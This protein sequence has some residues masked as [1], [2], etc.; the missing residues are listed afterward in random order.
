V[1]IGSQPKPARNEAVAVFGATGHT[2]RFVVSE[3]LRRGI[4]PIAIG[5]NAAK[6][7]ELGRDRGIELREASTDDANSLDRAFE[8]AAA[9]IN[10]AGP[11][12]GTA[13][14]V[15]SGALRSGIHYLDVTAEQASARAT[16]ETF[17]G[18]AR[19]AGVVVMPAMGFFGGFA[20]L[21]VTVAMNGWE[22]ADEITIGI[23]L[24]RW[25]PTRGT[26]MTGERNAAPRLC[27]VDG[28][29]VPV[30]RPPAETDW[31]FPHPFGRQKVIELPFSEV[32]LVARHIRTSELHTHLGRKALLDI[33]NP[34]TPPPE[35]ADDTGLSAQMFLVE[36]IVEAGGRTR[37]IAGRGRDIYAF[38]APLVCEAAERLLD[39]RALGSGARSPG[40]AFDA[41]DFLSTL[42][43]RHLTFE[44][45]DQPHK[46]SPATKARKGTGPAFRARS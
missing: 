40:A 19:D 9:V 46:T 14:P 37:R 36:A 4:A 1:V 29:L 39:G 3:L 11:F 33:R 24:D 5:R 27:I 12:L 13:Q 20:D 22:A 32:V 21:L 7:A 38:S 18:P 2:G 31:D 6:L 15:A 8:G 42:A 17:D 34:T 30:P 45:S 25:H 10:C 41:R 23:A 43:P 44:V 16:F 26:R 35:A 28:Q